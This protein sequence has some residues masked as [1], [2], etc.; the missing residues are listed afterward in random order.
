MGR[1]LNWDPLQTFSGDSDK[2]VNLWP[3]HRGLP[4]KYQASAG[5]ESAQ[6]FTA[7]IDKA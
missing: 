6:S 4:W 2:P 5:R 1:W 7:A 3:A